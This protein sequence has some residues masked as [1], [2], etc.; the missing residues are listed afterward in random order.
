MLYSY[1]CGPSGSAKSVLRQHRFGADQI[2]GLAWTAGTKLVDYFVSAPAATAA[3]EAVGLTPATFAS[4]TVGQLSSGERFQAGLARVLQHVRADNGEQHGEENCKGSAPLLVVVDE[5]TSALDRVT[6]VNVAR[7]VG[8]YIRNRGGRSCDVGSGGSGDHSGDDGSSGGAGCAGDGGGDDG[9]GAVGGCGT[10]SG[11]GCAAAALR[12]IFV[13]CHSDVIFH[14]CPDW[15]YDAGAGICRWHPHINGFG[16]GKVGVDDACVG[17]VG[18]NAVDDDSVVK[19]EFEIGA[20]V[21]VGRAQTLAQTAAGDGSTVVGSKVEA[22]A[23]SL[24]DAELEYNR[25]VGRAL[26]LGSG[27]FDLAHAAVCRSTRTELDSR[28]AAD[29]AT[30]SHVSG[31]RKPRGAAYIAITDGV[32]IPIPT[33][34]LTLSRCD[35]RE[36]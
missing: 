4:R 21:R 14:L 11:C 22:G 25:A 26:G 10:G 1:I 27:W 30:D 34:A 20:S 13:G 17:E 19:E 31:A 12:V 2:T 18:S 33:I 15:V 28:I 23:T 35:H 7:S 6:A 16:V 24:G 29:T 36:W 8:R 9:G 3:L 32:V 5:F